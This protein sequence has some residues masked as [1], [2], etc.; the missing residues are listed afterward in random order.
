M[1]NNA[2]FEVYN[3]RSIRIPKNLNTTRDLHDRNSSLPAHEQKGRFDRRTVF[4]DVFYQPADNKFIGLGPK[5]LNLNKVLR[6]MRISSGDETL[7]FSLIEIKSLCV[8]VVQ[9]PRRINDSTTALKFMF[10]DFCVDLE[11]DTSCRAETHLNH[12]S[13]RLTIINL[14]KDNHVEWIE[15]WIRWHNRLHNVQRLV[16]YDNG[17]SNRQE[18]EQSL[19]KLD[20]DM[21]IVLVGWPFEYGRSP[22]KFAQRGAMN[23]CR[24]RFAVPNGYCINADIDEYLVNKTGQSLLDYLD[25]VFV[26]EAVG[27]IRMRES[28]I[29]RQIPKNRKSF[30]LP[31]IW[32]QSFHRYDQGIQPFGKTKYIYRFDRIKYNS[33]H[34][35]IG[36]FP[37][38]QK[39]RFSWKDHLT[40]AISNN[41]FFTKKII[42]LNEQS[43]RILGV[44][45]APWS[46]LF[47]YHFRGLRKQPTRAD[48]PKIEEFDPTLHKEDIEIRDWCQKARLIPPESH[49]TE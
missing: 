2:S 14:Q 27:S 11:V 40:Y 21:K 41:R 44:Q 9:A 3:V 38:T 19:R 6:P 47:Y 36:Q 48:D 24:M 20:V 49:E 8:L 28:W 10:P 26:E 37:E 7:T 4:Y 42:G 5:W 13:Q 32:D 45:Y 29:P 46:Q 35:A 30:R 23:H 34:I 18:L 15:D 12:P 16:L 43:K 25:S 22:D 17:S 39:L 33:V 31:R 1:Q